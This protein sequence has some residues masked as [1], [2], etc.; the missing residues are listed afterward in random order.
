MKI[1]KIGTH[2]KPSRDSNADNPIH[3]HLASCLPEHLPGF[4]LVDATPP[5]VNR[6]DV[7]GAL[8]GRKDW[9]YIRKKGLY[10]NTSQGPVGNFDG[11]LVYE[12]ERIV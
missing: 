4:K 12:N 6:F 2:T 7:Q 9:S 1:L 3:E 8:R 11:S 5:G 10:V